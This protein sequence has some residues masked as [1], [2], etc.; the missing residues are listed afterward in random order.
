VIDAENLRDEKELMEQIRLAT[1]DDT[2]GIVQLID[3][4]LI[5]YG[6]RICLTDGGSEA[7]ILDIQSGYRDQGGE[8]WVLESTTDT[9][10][11]IVGT[12]AT[13]QDPNEPD[14]C[15]F[16]R[17]Y[18]HRELRGTKWGH[19]LMQ[20]TIDWAKAERKKSHHFSNWLRLMLT[21]LPEVFSSTG[22]TKRKPCVLAFVLRC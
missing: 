3:G 14:V 7:D 2:D 12:H 11:T 9:G 1:A 5:E 18:L 19:E 21:I 10:S 17:L 22:C 6:D 8:F 13:R 20:V 15:T 16:K 4:V